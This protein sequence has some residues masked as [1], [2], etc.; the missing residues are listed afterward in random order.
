MIIEYDT[1]RQFEQEKQNLLENSLVYIHEKKK[2]VSK[3]GGEWLEFI[4]EEVYHKESDIVPKFL[5]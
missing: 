3:I 2:T 5:E 4:E 1:E